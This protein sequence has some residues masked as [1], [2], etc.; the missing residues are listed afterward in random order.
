L[1]IVDVQLATPVAT[2]KMWIDNAIAHKSWV[3]LMF[4]QIDNGGDQYST[5]PANLQEII[6]YV[7]TKGVLTVINRQ[8][9]QLMLP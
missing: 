5:L 8:G 1:L 6:N 7:K 9:L 2:V 3:I 4:H